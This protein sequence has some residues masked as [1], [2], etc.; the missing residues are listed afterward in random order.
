MKITWQSTYQDCPSQ[1]HS[2]LE[3]INDNVE[4][5]LEL[6]TEIHILAYKDITNDPTV[7]RGPYFLW[8]ESLDGVDYNFLKNKS[9]FLGVLG[10]QLGHKD[11]LDIFKHAQTR[12]VRNLKQADVI[13]KAKSQNLKYENMSLRLTEQIEEQTKKLNESQLELESKVHFLKNTLQ[14]VKFFVESTSLADFL[15]KFKEAFVKE[16][17]KEVFLFSKQEDVYV[18][19][20]N[21]YGSK[22]FNA[23]DVMDIDKKQWA[24]IVSRPV[25]FFKTYELDE[26]QRY[27][28][29]FEFTATF[30]EQSAEFTEKFNFLKNVFMMIL[31]T[32]IDEEEIKRDSVLWSDSFKSFKD[33]VF[34]I[35]EFYRIMRSNF[36]SVHDRQPCYKVLFDREDPCPKCPITDFHQG[37]TVSSEG[38]INLNSKYDLNSFN[39]ALTTEIRQRLWIHH[40]EDKESINDLKG[41]FIKSEK[42]AYL[43]NLVDT[44][45]HRISNPLTGMKMATQMLLQEG[46]AQP[47]YEDIQEIYDGLNRCF[48]I[49]RNLKEFSESQM[50]ITDVRLSELV[51]STLV[52]MKSVT[53]SIRFDFNESLESYVWCSKGLTQQVLFN[54]IHNSCQAMDFAGE[55]QL[56]AGEIEGQKYLD[57]IDSGPGISENLQDKIF[58]PFFSTKTR[59]AGTGIG[60]FLSKL[61]MKQSGGDLLLMTEKP[62]TEKS[63]STLKGAHFRMLF[64]KLKT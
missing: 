55:I 56:V 32:L 16:N 49:I 27:F 21:I 8:I 41:Q 54:L 35:D 24:D 30:N 19:T 58:S 1:L 12:S 47:F 36:G 3:H 17:V 31:E 10:P 25:I 34:I 48:S 42:F 9:K 46:N 43:G 59:N 37:K 20:P 28:L 63:E 7:K 50:N 6:D 13:Q 23:Q 2:A 45:I 51:T 5:N 15:N 40:Y 44:V 57:I 61:I 11:L 38:S 64:P 52:L 39:F 4:L 18:L 33:P 14:I 53:R 62:E 60:L 29:G 26:D 22:R